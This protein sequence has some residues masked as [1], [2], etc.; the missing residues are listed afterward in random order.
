MQLILKTS[1]NSSFSSAAN[2]TT[3]EAALLKNL[4]AISEYVF[5]GKLTL[6]WEVVQFVFEQY[7]NPCFEAVRLV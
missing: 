7:R 6:V 1:K 5:M 4:Q 3:Y 2:C